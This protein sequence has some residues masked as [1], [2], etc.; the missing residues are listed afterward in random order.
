MEANGKNILSDS[1]VVVLVIPQIKGDNAILAILKELMNQKICYVT[2][3]KGTSYL[4]E[5]FIENNLS[6][7]NFFFIDTIS[8]SFKE[9]KEGKNSLFVSS[10]SDL[11]ELSVTINEVM[12]RQMFDAIIFDSLSS[13]TVYHR[14]NI[15]ALSKFIAN[16]VHAAYEKKCKLFFVCLEKDLKSEVLINNTHFIDQIIKLDEKYI[17]LEA[18]SSENEVKEVEQQ[19]KEIKQEKEEA[20]QRYYTRQITEEALKVIN[21]DLEKKTIELEVKLKNLGNSAINETNREEL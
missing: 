11:V 9:V 13:I 19:L 2:L 3:N 20:L 10:P 17:P 1:Q 7:E 4:T 16:T 5:K 21:N 8:A 18:L 15:P 12:K 6:I 14:N